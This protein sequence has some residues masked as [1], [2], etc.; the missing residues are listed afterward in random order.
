MNRVRT[1]VQFVEA[2]FRHWGALLTGGVPLALLWLYQGMGHTIPQW[3]YWAAGLLVFLPA[4]FFAWDEQRKNAEKFEAQLR[5]TDRDSPQLVL[6]WDY[7]EEARKFPGMGL[8]RTLI[9]ENRGKADAFN[10]QVGPI[11]LRGKQV[12]TATFPTIPCIRAG[13]RR[14]PTP[15]LTGNIQEGHEHKL[16]MVFYN[17][18]EV[19]P[20]FASK[21]PKDG[22]LWITFPISIGF[23]D[24]NQNEYHTT[25]SFKADDWFG[26]G[27]PVEIHLLD[28]SV[29]FAEPVANRPR[30]LSNTPR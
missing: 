24:Y 26:T 17:S 6:T 25:F 14:D 13:E 21:D 23:Q 4:A 8:D 2:V 3:L 5:R 29:T 9:I 19:A 22:R 11:C 1:I 12:V 18:G 20:E 30:T 28:T 10:I 16:E 15:T 27:T 7:S